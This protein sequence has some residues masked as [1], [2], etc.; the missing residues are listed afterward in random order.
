M[1]RTQILVNNSDSFTN[2]LIL[3]IHMIYQ[4]LVMIWRLLHYLKGPIGQPLSRG[5]VLFQKFLQLT[6]A[7]EYCH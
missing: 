7:R 2:G 6:C 1:A 4:L 5:A 3:V